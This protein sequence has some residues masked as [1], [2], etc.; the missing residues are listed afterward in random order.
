MIVNGEYQTL[1]HNR[2]NAYGA[3]NR[4][5][6]KPA[7]VNV[8]VRQVKDED[9]VIAVNACA[10]GKF[11]NAALCVALVENGIR[12]KITG[13]ENKGRTLSMD[14]IVLDFQ[15]PRDSWCHRRRVSIQRKT[16][17]QAQD[18][19]GGVRSA[20]RQHVDPR[21]HSTPVRALGPSAAPNGR[22]ACGRRPYPSAWTNPLLLSTCD[23]RSSRSR[24]RLFRSDVTA[25]ICSTNSTLSRLASMVFATGK[26]TPL[27]ERRVVPSVLKRMQPT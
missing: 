26:S 4:V 5:L 18:E 23:S 15:Y 12:R 3:I 11:E 2:A 24:M 6:K 9:G 17:C 14:N 10:L 25:C 13:G 1:G 8:S 7:K 27:L 19:R 20:D 16:G 22:R 21:A